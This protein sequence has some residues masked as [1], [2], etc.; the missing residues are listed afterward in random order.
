MNP[1]AF[2]QLEFSVYIPVPF[3]LHIFP[4][5]AECLIDLISF[6]CGGS[7]WGFY[8]NFSRID[9]SD[10]WIQKKHEDNQSVTV[11]KCWSTVDCLRVISMAPVDL[12]THSELTDQ[13]KK[14]KDKEEQ[15]EEKE[16]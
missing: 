15:Q 5:E 11:C 3:I 9:Q 8:G 10:N 1:G 16:E 6:E 12:R 2:A 14:K 7:S 13:L 4:T